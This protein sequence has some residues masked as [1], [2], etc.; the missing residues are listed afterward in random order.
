MNEIDM[1]QEV[2]N[3]PIKGWEIE[4]NMFFLFSFFLI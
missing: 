2:L 3:E 4:R 1:E